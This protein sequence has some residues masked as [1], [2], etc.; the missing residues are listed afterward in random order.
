[1]IARILIGLR[2]A[3]IFIDF[4]KTYASVRKEVLYN[5]LIEFSILM[6]VARLIKVSELKSRLNTGYVCYHSV[7]NL[8]SYSLLSRN[9]K[10]KIYKTIMLPIVLYGCETWV[11]K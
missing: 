5:I 2:R 7:Q 11:S 10:I 4:K 8:L 3:A 9:L 1:V 6:K